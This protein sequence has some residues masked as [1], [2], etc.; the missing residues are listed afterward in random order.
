VFYE[1][2]IITKLDG[3][4]QKGMLFTMLSEPIRIFPEGMATVSDSCMS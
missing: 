3:I 4:V 1:K 2:K